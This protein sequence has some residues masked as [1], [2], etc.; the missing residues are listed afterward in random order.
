MSESVNRHKITKYVWELG[1]LHLNQDKYVLNNNKFYVQNV[2][3]LL[4]T[5]GFTTKQ[6][7]TEVNFEKH[8]NKYLTWMKYNYNIT[9]PELDE[10]F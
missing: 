4:A 3:P 1:K 6:L 5:V 7:S 2:P 8:L 10:D 9:Q